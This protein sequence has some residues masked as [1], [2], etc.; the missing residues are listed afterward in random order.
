MAGRDVVVLVAVVLGAYAAFASL[1]KARPTGRAIVG[2]VVD[3]DTVTLRGGR[4]VRLLQIDAPERG[5][6]ECYSRAS[7][8]ALRTLLPRG[9]RVR[10]VAD[11]R[12][13]RV[14]R[15][16][17]LLRYVYRGSV[18]VNVA[19]ARRGTATVWLYGR[20]R[21]RYA[22]AL[23]AAARKARLARR[24]IWGACITNWNPNAP[25]R[26]STREQR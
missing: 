24:G 15:Y 4:R 9:T 18:N 10:L 16:G 7:A 8:R 14:D 20:K 17:R 11:R 6:G 3:G 22:R 1:G 19:L 23:L 13:D 2:G 21:G 12:L 5:T 25:A 26:H